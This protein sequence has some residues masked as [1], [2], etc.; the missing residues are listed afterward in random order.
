MA[1]ET[2]KRSRLQSG[3]KSLRVI[4]VGLS[5]SKAF[6]VKGERVDIEIDYEKRIIRA[7]V[8]ETGELK[9]SSGGT[10]SC[11]K[12]SARIK[13]INPKVDH[14]EMKP[15]ADGWSYGTF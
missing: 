10:V 11:R 1:F 4:K 12:V 8:N 7:K 5:A 3:A 13:A 9:V 15:Q 6:A 2:I 14:I